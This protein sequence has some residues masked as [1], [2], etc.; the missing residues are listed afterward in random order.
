MHISLYNRSVVA[1]TNYNEKLKELYDGIVMFEDE[2]DMVGATIKALEMSD[3]EREKKAL[4]YKKILDEH[5]ID[6][7]FIKKYAKKNKNIM[8]YLDNIN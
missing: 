6:D 1:L 7:G 8:G 2:Y 4:E 3:E 5:E